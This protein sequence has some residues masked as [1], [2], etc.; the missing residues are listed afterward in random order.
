[1]MQYVEGCRSTPDR[2]KNSQA[3]SLAN[4]SDRHP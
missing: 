4:G 2:P 3:Q 1:L